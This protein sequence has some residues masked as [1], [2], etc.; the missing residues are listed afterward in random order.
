MAT[1]VADIR[2]GAP[3]SAAA[4]AAGIDGS[5][6][7]RWLQRGRAQKK[8]GYQ[9]FAREVRTARAVCHVTL[10]KDVY[11]AGRAD[12]KLGLAI[13]SKRFAKHWADKDS[14]QLRGSESE[15]PRL[16]ITIVQRELPGSGAEVIANAKQV[17]SAAQPHGRR[18]GQS[19]LGQGEGDSSEDSEGI[20]EGGQGEDV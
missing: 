12:G 10:A 19:L 2:N 11:A 4:N 20:C 14:A 15:P 16:S 5:T 8:N 1:I 18:R 7:R 17:P 3:A 6:F 13:L 9:A